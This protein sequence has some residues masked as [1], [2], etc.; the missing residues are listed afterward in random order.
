[1]S[2]VRYAAAQALRDAIVVN[3]IDHVVVTGDVTEDGRIVEFNQFNEIFGS[4]RKAGQLS[5]VPGNHD[6]RGDAVGKQMMPTE[7]VVTSSHDGMHL[8]RI[9]STAPHNRFSWASHGKISATSCADVER[10]LESAKKGDFVVVAVHHH[11]LPL[12]EETFLEKISARFGFPYAKELLLGRSLLERLRG[13]VD[14]V[15][16]GHRHVPSETVIGDGRRDVR[17]YNAGSSTALGRFRV[18]SHDQGALVGNPQWVDSDVN[19]RT[20]H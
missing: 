17:V 13:R 14:L 12:P 7:R 4:L 1:L 15:L 11:L 3:H 19:S 10:S 18:F 20:F 5:V 6:C 16:H 2:P 9:D 8:I